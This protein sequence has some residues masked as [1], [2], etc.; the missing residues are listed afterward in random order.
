MRRKIWY[1]LAMVLFFGL[2]PV[3]VNNVYADSHIWGVKV[4]DGDYAWTYDTKKNVLS[5][6]IVPKDAKE[7]LNAEVMCLAYPK[8]V[9]HLSEYDKFIYGEEVPSPF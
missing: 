9:K 8:Q 7:N 3:A 6:C 4:P 1:A 2:L 5:F